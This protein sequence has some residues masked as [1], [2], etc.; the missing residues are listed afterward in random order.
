MGSA[1]VAGSVSE[2]VY[3]SFV[4]VVSKCVE[5]CSSSND[6]DEISGAI[7]EVVDDPE[8]QEEIEEATQEVA[9]HGN[10]ES[11]FTARDVTV[12]ENA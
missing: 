2:R 7:Q 8:I 6:P 4:F 12:L 5:L 1:G 9:Q 3:D 10:L 11:F